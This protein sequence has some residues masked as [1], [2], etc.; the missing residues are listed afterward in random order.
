[1]NKRRKNQ[2]KDEYV[3]NTGI[4]R[5]KLNDNT[6]FHCELCNLDLSLANSGKTD[7]DDHVRSVKH[8]RNLEA[9]VS[10]TMITAYMP[11]LNT[12]TTI[13]DKAAA[14]EGTWA[15]HSA[16]HARSFLSNDCDSGLFKTLFPDSKIAQKY[17]SARTKTAAIIT[18]VQ[19]HPF[20]KLVLFRCS[21][22]DVRLSSTF[23]A[24]LS[25]VFNRH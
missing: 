1:M 12:P 4:K 15:Y 17:G 23:T 20:I 5:S 25:T 16:I 2:F 9:T 11:S 8:Q 19:N 18:G 3:N 6:R 21:G 24:W 7:V 14:A 10:S 22:S 13:D